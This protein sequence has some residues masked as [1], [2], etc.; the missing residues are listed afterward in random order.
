L[1][2]RAA[3]AR[4]SVASFEAGAGSMK[5]HI[6]LLAAGLAL[7]TVFQTPVCDPGSQGQQ[8]EE[9]GRIDQLNTQ[10]ITLFK[11]N[12]VDEALPLAKQ[13]LELNEKV[14]GP[15]ALNVATA[16]STLAELYI[17]KGKYR[18]AEPLLLRAIEINDKELEPNHPSLI[19]TL[20]N[21]TCILYLSEL[22]KKLED[23]EKSRRAVLERS[24]LPDRF[25]GAVWRVSKPINVPRPN[26][27]TGVGSGRVLIAATVDEKGKVISTQN[28]CGGNVLLVRASL[29]SAN[30]AR[31][32]P[33][34][35][36]GVPVRLTGYLPYR[37][38]RQ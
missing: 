34:I 5:T 1:R 7:L 22:D 12:K 28:M 38:E 15:D 18:E 32:K 13:L 35:I 30:K 9:L 27:P 4:R 33:L 36:Q 2:G 24:S 11:A 26:F 20:K 29:E 6:G 19:R 17:I 3:Q 31:F 37:F 8:N 14:F 23:F 21:Y 10:V 25:W 16:A